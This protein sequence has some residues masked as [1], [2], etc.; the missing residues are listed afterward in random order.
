[1]RYFPELSL[2]ALSALGCALF[3]SDLSAQ[4]LGAR[5]GTAER[6]RAYYR[7]V[8]LPIPE[9]LVVEAGAFATLPDGRARFLIVTT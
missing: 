1:M 4:E 2:R 5:W 3:A 8:E 6:E 9:G 7:I